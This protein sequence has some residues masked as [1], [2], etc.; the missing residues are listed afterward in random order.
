[1]DVQQERQCGERPVEIE[2]R[3]VP[4]TRRSGDGGRG[5]QRGR[6]A[7]ASPGEPDASAAPALVSVAREGTGDHLPDTRGGD[8]LDEVVGDAGVQD[9]PAVTCVV[10]GPQCH[11]GGPGL[12]DG[13][14]FV[15]AADGIRG[16]VEI[17]QD[18]G[19][20][21][22]ARQRADGGPDIA[23]VRFQLPFRE[24]DLKREPRLRVRDEG[25]GVPEVGGLRR[26]PG[27][28]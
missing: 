1:M 7:A 9:G 24:G 28:G 20:R 3:N 26:G 15:D 27:R 17:D 21:G 5:E 8:W 12:T 19:R 11:D 23:V 13:C 2:H 22:T 18:K 14:E 10:P 6:T 16:A 4:P 25:P